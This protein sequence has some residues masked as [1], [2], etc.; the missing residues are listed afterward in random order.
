MVITNP[1]TGVEINALTIEDVY[2]LAGKIVMELLTGAKISNQ[3]PELEKAWSE[4]GAIHGYGRMPAAESGT[5]NK[6]TT[7]KSAPH[8]PEFVSEYFQEF[9]EKRY[10]V[11]YRLQ[12]AQL[13]LDGAMSFDTFVAVIVNSLAEGYRA[14]TNRAMRKALGYQQVSGDETDNALIILDASGDVVEDDNS[15]LGSLGQFEVLTT[16]TYADIYAKLT[17]VAKKFPKQN[18][19]YSAG[20]E[21]GADINECHIYLPIDF[22]AKAGV[23]FLSKWNNQGEANKLPTI[24]ETDGLSFSHG[25]ATRCVALILE[26]AVIAHVEKHRE[27]IDYTDVDRG[28]A[29]G[30]SM[31]VIDGIPLARYWKAYAIVFDIPASSDAVNVNISG[32]IEGVIE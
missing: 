18:N 32:D 31:L 15:L 17:E 21:A 24:H 23:N 20:F 26:E 25:A 27:T 19:D 12:D 5:V 29:R 28:H 8:Y 2:G 22:T 14:D 7:A 30:V 10:W 6:N 13:V 9:T 1:I 11:D 16:P 3:Y 4:W